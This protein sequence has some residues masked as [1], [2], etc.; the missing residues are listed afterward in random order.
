LT[1]KWDILIMKFNPQG[2][3][4]L[5]WTFPTGELPGE[6]GEIH[7]LAVDSKGNVYASEVGATTRVQKFI[8]QA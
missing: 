2:R 5:N 3:V 4:L 6:F 8:P 1:V 7:G